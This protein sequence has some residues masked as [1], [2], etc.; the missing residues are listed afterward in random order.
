MNQVY[1]KIKTTLKWNEQKSCSQVKLI[2]KEHFL[3]LEIKNLKM[4]RFK[5]NKSIKFN[6]N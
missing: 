6:L 2:D 5:E 1:E 3:E 4:S